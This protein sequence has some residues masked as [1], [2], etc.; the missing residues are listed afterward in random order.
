MTK[1]NTNDRAGTGLYLRV[2]PLANG[3]PEQSFQAE[4]SYWR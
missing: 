4:N 3:G 2:V 1:R